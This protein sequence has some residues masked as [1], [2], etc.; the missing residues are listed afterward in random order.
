MQEYRQK[1][2]KEITINAIGVAPLLA[3][4]ILAWLGGNKT[5][6]RRGSFSGLLER[7]HRRA[8]LWNYGTYD[9]G[10]YN[11]RPGP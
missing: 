4:Q 10:H 11:R 1:L 6:R 9:C 2:K 5:R 8:W 7:L 3:V